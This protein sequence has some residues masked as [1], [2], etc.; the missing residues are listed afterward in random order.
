MIEIMMKY[1]NFN[2]RDINIMNFK[3]IMLFFQTRSY[4]KYI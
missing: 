2:L 4:N 3:I 1:N